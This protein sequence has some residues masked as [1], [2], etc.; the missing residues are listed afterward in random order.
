MEKLDLD[1]AI[2][3]HDGAVS[4]DAID[5]GDQELHWL[6][7]ASNRRRAE[8]HGRSL[9]KVV[10]NEPDQSDIDQTNQAP[11]V[12]HGKLTDLVGLHQLDSIGDGG[13]DRDCIGIGRHDDADRTIKICLAPLLEEA[14]KVA[15][16]EDSKQDGVV[17]VIKT[18]PEGRRGPA[19]RTK[20]D[21]TV[22]SR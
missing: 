19:S 7:P 6:A 1:P 22:S 9:H 4:Q 20:T 17:S 11:T 8:T 18:A 2:V 13:A 3:Q 16:S 15:I 21:R 5:I 12:D 14:S 10:G